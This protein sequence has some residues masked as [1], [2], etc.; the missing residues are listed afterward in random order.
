MRLAA[1]LAA[2]LLTGC[3][4]QAPQPTDP[5]PTGYSLHYGESQRATIEACQEAVE[6]VARKSGITPELAKRMEIQE[7][8][9]RMYQKCLLDQGAAI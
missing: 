2:I 8:A 5:Q 1:A 7:I 6:I 4:V 3:A 9:K